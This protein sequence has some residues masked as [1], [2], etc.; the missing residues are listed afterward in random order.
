MLRIR[1][2]GTPI[3]ILSVI[4]LAL[5]AP[6]LLSACGGSQETS[7]SA[8]APTSASAQTTG[9]TGESSPGTASTSSPTTQQAGTTT[10]SLPQTTT[11]V[12]GDTTTSTQ[13][14]SATAASSSSTTPGF[15]TT[16]AAKPTT[17]T[18]GGPVVLKVSGPSGVKQLSMADLKGMTATSGYGG[19]KNDVQNIS[20]PYAWKGVSVRALMELVGGGGSATFVASDGYS[21]TL[22][23]D[24]IGGSLTT[25]DPA[26]GE[27]ITSINGRVKAIVAYAKDGAAL[28]SSEGPLRLAFVSPAKDEVTTSKYWVR[29]VIELDVQ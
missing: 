24:M 12:G 5:A 14:S 8:Q 10:Q 21:Q 28:S 13:G 26:T 11:T 4:L 1:R 16:T 7:E 22:S 27:E 19:W 17:T 3:A 23:V 6:G 25:Y 20:G 29:Q 18:A 9:S 15:A 2:L